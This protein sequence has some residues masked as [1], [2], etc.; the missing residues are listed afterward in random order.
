MT[1]AALIPSAT[2]AL[3]KVNAASTVTTARDPNVTARA[4]GWRSGADVISDRS[5]SRTTTAQPAPTVAAAPSGSRYAYRN[6]MIA[7]RPPNT[8]GMSAAMP[9]PVISAV[10]TRALA[11]IWLSAPPSAARMRRSQDGL[12]P[13]V[14]A[15]TAP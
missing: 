12:S 1:R 11:R 3:A 6:E 4:A 13:D 5:K 10:S 9:R 7:A 2:I 15:T 14:L 8:A